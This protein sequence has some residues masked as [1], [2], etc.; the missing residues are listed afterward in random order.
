MWRRTRPHNARHI[1]QH[2]HIIVATRR[3]ASCWAGRWGIR[4]MLMQAAG[5]LNLHTEVIVLPAKLPDLLQELC[6]L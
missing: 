1:V 2:G 5:C 4:V 6:N 3:V